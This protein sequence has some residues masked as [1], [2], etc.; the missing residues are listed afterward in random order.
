MF[1]EQLSLYLNQSR[2][3]SSS[4]VK[5]GELLASFG[6]N[7]LFSAQSYAEKWVWTIV[8]PMTYSEEVDFLIACSF[9]V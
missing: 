9:Q 5:T 7:L 3:R 8:R 1:S 2:V 6:K 4:S